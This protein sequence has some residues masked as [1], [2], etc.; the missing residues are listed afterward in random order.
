M[1]VP[2]RRASRRVDASL[3]SRLPGV[4]ALARLFERIAMVRAGRVPV[5]LLALLPV[6]LAL[7]VFDAADELVLGPVGVA[8]SFVAE[9]AFLLALTGSAV[10]ALGFAAIDLVPGIDIVP[11]ATLTLVRQ[12]VRAW[13]EGGT[14]RPAPRDVIDV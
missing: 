8:L 2:S 12:I 4:G 11:F 6:A 13:K 1:R 5:G 10:P 14:A 9:A 3:A 7:D